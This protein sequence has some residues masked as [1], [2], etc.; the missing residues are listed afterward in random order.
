MSVQKKTK[1]LSRLIPTAQETHE[2]AVTLACRCV[3]REPRVSRLYLI[4]SKLYK[5]ILTLRC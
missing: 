2:K 5:G 4:C 3:V 1:A